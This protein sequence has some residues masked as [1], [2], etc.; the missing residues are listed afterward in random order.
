MTMGECTTLPATSGAPAGM[1]I[2]VERAL[3]LVCAFE[4]GEIWIAPPTPVPLV[5]IH[6][7]PRTEETPHN[8]D[9]G[10]DWLPL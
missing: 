1:E 8:P 5:V 2:R 10:R 9:S 4:S 6:A 3:G 7:C